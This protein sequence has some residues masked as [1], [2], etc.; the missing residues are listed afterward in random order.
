MSRGRLF[1]KVDA[2]PRPDGAEVDRDGF[3]RSAII[4]RGKLMRFDP[5]GR[6]EREVP[7]PFKFPTMVAFGG[8]DLRTLS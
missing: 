3:Y 1:A 4:G 7:V 8:A 5:Q 2:P 6:V